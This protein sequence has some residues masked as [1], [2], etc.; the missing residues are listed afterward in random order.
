MKIGI[1]DPY[2][3]ILGGAEK[4]VLAIS[5]CF[6]DDEITFFNTEK[7]LLEKAENK[8]GIKLNKVVL[9]SWPADRQLRRQILKEL[10]IFFY[11]TDGSL[12]FSPAKINILIIQSPVHIP[13]KNLINQLKIKSWHK[14]VCYSEFI[15]K[16]IKNK[17]G[18][19]SHT[20]FVPIAKG[21]AAIKSNKNMILTVGR[22]FPHLHNKKQLEMVGFFRQLLE[23]RPD[24]QLLLAGSV[25]PGGQEYFEKVKLAAKDLPVTVYDKTDSIK[26]NE[27]YSRAKI[28]WHAAGF[29]ENLDKFPERA[30]HFGVSTIEA[31]SY[32]TVPVVYAGGGQK[33]LVDDGKNGNTWTTAEELINKSVELLQNEKLSSQM[34]KSAIKFSD[35][36]TVEK[37]CLRLHEIIKS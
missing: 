26:L 14:I 37:F 18:W 1:Y 32:G 21:H 5:A 2:F 16:I 22:F 3:H 28:Y 13:Q 11:I 27:L 15:K 6:P 17:T 24:T 10:D 29:G 8:F 25:D 23:R 33:E 19:N 4:Y 9:L 12:F 35:Q 36:F 34:A 20:L 31:M 30:E 7:G